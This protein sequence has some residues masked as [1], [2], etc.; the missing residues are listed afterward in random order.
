MQTNHKIIIDSAIAHGLFTEEEVEDII[1]SMGELPLHT[2]D[3]WKKR[4]YQVKKGEKNS[5]E[6]YIWDVSKK[7]REE[8][9]EDG[10]T[11]ERL[12]YF[13]KKAFFFTLE[14]VE[15]IGE[16]RNEAKEKPTKAKKSKK[17]ETKAEPKE[18]EKP[19]QAKPKKET[20]KSEYYI[21]V[22]TGSPQK[23]NGSPTKVEGVF[24]HKNDNGEY[25]LSDEKTGAKLASKKTKK[26]ALAWLEDKSNKE[27]LD[28][29]RSSDGYEKLAKEFVK[30]LEKL[31]KAERKYS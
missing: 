19:K 12:R 27:R 7:K 17:A 6:A 31:H 24:I 16:T 10:N 18:T 5:L 26:E 21:N 14:Q 22:K 3:G 20:R 28:R 1:S 13:K 8:T 11:I 9:D 30:K 23:V 2:Y 15:K 29:V 25:Q 4:G